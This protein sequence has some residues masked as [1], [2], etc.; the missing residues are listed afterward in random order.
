MSRF[1][2]KVCGVTRTK[3][4]TLIARLGA[5]LIGMIFYR[6]SK[7]FVT[8]KAA[9]EIIG[10]LPPTVSRV[11]VF[12]D[13]SLS[14]ILRIADKLR[15]DYIQLHGCEPASYVTKLQ[16]EGYRVIKAFAIKAQ[17]DYLAV[18]R[19]CADLCLLDHQTEQLVGGTG[20]S[21]DWQVRPQRKINNLVLAGGITVDNVAKGVELFEPLMVDVNSGVETRPGVKSSTRLKAFMAECDR[22]RYGK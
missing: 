11:G 12:V 8:Q 22:I 21:F 6:R 3:D 20:K 4:A 9:R 14:K 17:V 15:L 19:S 7:R 13:E 1:R 5:D 18:K 2:V 16:R 10:V